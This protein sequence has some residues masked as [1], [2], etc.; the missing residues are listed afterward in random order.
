MRVVFG[1]FTVDAGQRRVLASGRDV[2]LAPKAFELLLALLENRPKAIAKQELFKRLW[3]DAFV[4][5][6]NL[7]TL[8]GDLRAAL[9]DDAQTPRWIRTVY[10]YGY[11]FTGDVIDEGGSAS[12]SEP[13]RWALIHD[14]GE[15]AL[16]AGVNIIGRAGR[17]TSGLASPTVSRQHARLSIAGERVIV[18]DLGSRNGTWVAGAAA[19]SPTAAK[20]GDEIRF[21][22]LVA[23]LRYSPG[24]ATTEALDGSPPS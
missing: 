14:H 17:G 24:A 6:N 5:E 21:G 7:P 18:E 19:L 2:R 13:S 3:P 15:I 9:G 16:C 23:V 11:A 12:G 10:G 8:I 20:D 22:G 4:T 1:E